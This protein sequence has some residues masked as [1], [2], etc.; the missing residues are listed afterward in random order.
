MLDAPIL[1]EAVSVHEDER[2]AA[3]QTALTETRRA[4]RRQW[5]RFWTLRWENTLRRPGWRAEEETKAWH[6]MRDEVRRYAAL[7]AQI[8]TLSVERL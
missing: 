8:R 7:R 1:A 4:W 3:L 2:L 6:R 5:G